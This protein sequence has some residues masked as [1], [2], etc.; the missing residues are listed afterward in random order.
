MDDSCCSAALLV[1][2]L[3]GIG[4]LQ[5]DKIVTGDVRPVIKHGKPDKY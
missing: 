2:S 3:F 5:Q 4:L 1:I